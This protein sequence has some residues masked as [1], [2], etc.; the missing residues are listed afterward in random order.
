MNAED[1]YDSLIS[2]FAELYKR[3]PQQIKR[4]IRIESAFNPNALN[5]HSGAA[6]LAQFTVATWAEWKDARPGIAVES[7]SA[8]DRRQVWDRYNP[9]HAIHAMCGYVAWLETY[10]ERWPR[11]VTERLAVTLAA[12][13]FGIGRLGRIITEHGDQWREHVPAETRHYIV[14]G[15]AYGTETLRA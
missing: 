1:R 9:E 2:Y 10:G 12:Y 15:L 11:P 13:N 7:V 5:P 4:Q 14:K 6:G 8:S 3:T